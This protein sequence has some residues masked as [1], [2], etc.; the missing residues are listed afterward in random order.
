MTPD[1]ALET[2]CTAFAARD[3]AAI[4]ALFAPGGLYEIPFVKNRLVGDAEIRAGL[5]AMFAV[6][7]TCDMTLDKVRASGTAAIGEG[8][9][10]ASLN[11]AGET[12]DAAFGIVAE[13]RDGKLARLSVYLDARPYRLWADGPILALPARA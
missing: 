7:E 9:L 12:V 10:T 2:Y 6:V 1:T 5:A 11:R 8:R 13:T 4:G 3:A